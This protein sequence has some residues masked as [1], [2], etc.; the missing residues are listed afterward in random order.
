MPYCGDTGGQPTPFSFRSQFCQDFEGPCTQVWTSCLLQ[1]AT[2]L[3]PLRPKS[4]FTGFIFLR[5]HLGKMSVKTLEAG[6]EQFG[7]GNSRV[8]VGGGWSGREGGWNGKRE[9]LGWSHISPWALRFFT[10]WGSVSR[11]EPSNS[12]VLKQSFSRPGLKA[13]LGNL[14][15]GEFIK[16]VLLLVNILVEI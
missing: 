1:T 11:A 16:S 3:P 7:A 8:L 14:P 10:L 5:T 12:Q 9:D 2:S 13:T 4:I 15:N 6:S